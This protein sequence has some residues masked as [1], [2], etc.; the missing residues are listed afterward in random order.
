MDI[1][2]QGSE[3]VLIIFFSQQVELF[4]LPNCNHRQL[5]EQLTRF[6]RRSKGNY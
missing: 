5:D 3:K 2:K 4:F 6:C 1:K